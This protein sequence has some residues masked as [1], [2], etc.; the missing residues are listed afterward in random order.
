MSGFDN[1]SFTVRTATGTTDTLLATDSI[2]IYTNSAA[3]TVT[4]PPVATTQP[5]RVYRIICQNTGVLTLDGNA[6]ENVNG[7]TTFAMT[8]GTVGGVTGRAAVVSDG[9]Q[10]F[11]LY[12]Q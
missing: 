12:S 1:T 5:G 4:L 10:W 3:K 8:A 11:T 6:S 7:A 2:V 9:T